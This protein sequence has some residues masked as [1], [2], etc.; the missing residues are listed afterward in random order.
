MMGEACQAPSVC[1][2]RRALHRVRWR[3]SAARRNSPRIPRGR[4]RRTTLRPWIPCCQLAK[5]ARLREAL[6]N[7]LLGRQRRAANSCE[8][9][10][11][12]A[13]DV[14]LPRTPETKRCGTA[15]VTGEVQV[16]SRRHRSKCTVSR[17]AARVLQHGMPWGVR[18]KDWSNPM[19]MGF[20]LRTVWCAQVGRPGR[21][22]AAGTH[23]YTAQGCGCYRHAFMMAAPR[24]GVGAS[25]KGCNLPTLAIQPPLSSCPRSCSSLA[26]QRG[27]LGW[28]RRTMGS[29][30]GS[31]RAGRLLRTASP[32]LH[33]V[34]SLR[35]NGAAREVPCGTE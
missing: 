21:M 4:P 6:A 20:C 13:A 26:G 16:S 5:N 7:P 10:L 33:R 35:A 32:M 27:A 11:P 18:R 31:S 34:I 3:C 29:E 19:T 12:R 8:S 30:C 17:L 28:R 22:V 23:Q 1:G 2:P 15:T 25:S 24:S 14:A 9:T